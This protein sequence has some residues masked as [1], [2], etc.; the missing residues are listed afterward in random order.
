[1]T[2]PVDFSEEIAEIIAAQND[3]DNT[4]HEY[5]VVQTRVAKKLGVKGSI[6][7]VKI[8]LGLSPKRDVNSINE[9]V[10]ALK[11]LSAAPAPAEISLIERIS[12]LENQNKI[13]EARLEKLEQIVSVNKNL[14][15]RL[16]NLEKRFEDLYKRVGV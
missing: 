4:N 12:M 2:K 7:A 15:E 5:H 9:I 8:A 6:K 16:A 13:L 11:K 3:P 10:E 1:M 14:E